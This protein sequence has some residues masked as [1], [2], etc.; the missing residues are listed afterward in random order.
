MSDNIITIK[1]T[2][3]EGG[4]IQPSIKLRDLRE[5]VDTVVGV[6]EESEVLVTVGDGA[7]RHVPADGFTITSLA[8]ED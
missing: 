4:D 5:F 2:A 7:V 6:D 3:T 1:V 8:V